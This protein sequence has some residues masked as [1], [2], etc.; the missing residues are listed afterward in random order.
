MTKAIWCSCG[1]IDAQLHFPATPIARR[2]IPVP[3]RNCD[4]MS[5]LVNIFISYRKQSY[6]ESHTQNLHEDVSLIVQDK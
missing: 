6:D 4:N 2:L 5:A 3:D 1:G